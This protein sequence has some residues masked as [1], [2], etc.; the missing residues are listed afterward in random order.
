MKRVSNRRTKK[1]ITLVELVVAM[2]LTAMFAV[3]CIALIL[4]VTNI[5]TQTNKISQSQLVADAVVDALRAECSKTIV[6]DT[7]DVW[8]YNPSAYDGKVL[9]DTDVIPSTNGGGVLVLRRNSTYCET[10]AANY[11]IDDTLVQKVREK[12]AYGSGSTGTPSTVTTKSVYDISAEDAASGYIHYGY[13][14]SSAVNTKGLTY[15][16]PGDYYDYT[17][18]FTKDAYMGYTVNLNFHDIKYNS[19]LMPVFVQC[20][21]TVMGETEAAYTR[22]VVLCFS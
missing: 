16:Y 13:Y 12:D 8:I 22:T 14:L 19:D 21:V 9:A 4:P 6:T 18:P 17:S 20:D 7:A 2:A 10:I 1:A 15:I 11:V 3:A 5:Y